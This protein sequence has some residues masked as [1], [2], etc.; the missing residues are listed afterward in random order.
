ML[1]YLF[2][3]KGFGYIILIWINESFKTLFSSGSILWSIIFK[4]EVLWTSFENYFVGESL[5]VKFKHV[6]SFFLK[7]EYF[8]LNISLNWS[9][10]LI[11]SIEITNLHVNEPK[12][13]HFQ[14]TLHLQMPLLLE[15]QGEAR[16]VEKH[17]RSDCS[18]AS[19]TSFK[20]LT[21]CWSWSAN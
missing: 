8:L 5:V 10:R 4:L 1:V 20:P 14:T 18:S 15:E 9:I 6:N 17:F 19:Y 3:L 13:K 16:D 2:I 11:K 21:V 12:R 7:V